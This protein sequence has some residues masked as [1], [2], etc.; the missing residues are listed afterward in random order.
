MSELLKKYESIDQSK[1]KEAFVKVLDRVKKLTNDF[2]TE[3]KKNNEIAEQVLDSV[4]QK[5]PDAIKIVKREPKSKPAPKKT[6]K[7]KH[8]AKATHK[9][10][11]APVAKN[12]DNNIMTVAK[13]IQKAGESWKDAMERAKVVLKERKEKVFEKQ[14]TELEKLYALVKT[15][16]ELIGFSK[17]DIERDAVRDAKPKG[18]RFVTKEG[19]TSNQYGTYDNKL[20]RKYWETRDRHSDRLSPNYPKNMPLLAEGGMTDSTSDRNFII[21][22][23]YIENYPNDELGEEIEA[24]TTF[25]DIWNSLNNGTNVY[26][27]LGVGDSLVRERVFEEL[28]KIYGVDYKYVYDKWLD[29][30]KY[31]DG[32]SIDSER[33][34]NFLKDD[35][36]KLQKAINEDDTEQIEIFF[37]YWLGSS[38]HLKSLET[39]TNDRMYNFLKEDLETLEKAINDGNKEEVERFFSYWGQ[40]LESLKMANGG[41]LPYMTDPNFGDFQNTGSFADGGSVGSGKNGYVAFYKGKQIDVYA[42]TKYEAQKL[43]SQHF[44]AKKDYEVNVVLAELDGK[45]YINSAMFAKGGSFSDNINVYEKGKNYPVK[46]ISIADYEKYGLENFPNFSKSGSISGMKKQYY[47]KDALLVRCGNYIYNVTSKPEIYFNGAYELGGMFMNTDLAGHTGGGTGG[48]D[49]NAPLNGFSGTHYTGLVG[50]TGAMSSGELF[51]AGGAMAQNQQVIN[52]ASQSYVNYYLG[53]GAGQGIYKDGGSIPNNYEGRTAENVWKNWTEAQ[54]SHFLLDHSELLDK[55]RMENNLGY[56]RTIQKDKTFSELTPLTK[57]VLEAHIEKGQYAKGGALKDVDDNL[58]V[59]ISK[60]Q[61]DYWV[62]TSK[63]TTKEQAEEMARLVTSV[64]GETQDVKTVGQV[65]AHSKTIYENGGSIEEG[66]RVTITTNSLGKDYV[67]MSGTIT[68]RKLLNDKYSVK[69]S[70]GLEMAFSKDEFKHDSINPR[71]ADGGAFAPNVSNGTQ[72]MSEVYA[73]GGAIDGMLNKKIQKLA[74]VRGFEIG[75]WATSEY[76]KIMTQA[77]VESLTDAN[78]HDEAKEVVVKAEGKT[79]W[80]DDLYQ[81]ESFNPDEKVSSFAREVARECDYDGYDIIN[82][83]FFITKTA[84]SKV[85]TMIEDLFLK[86]KTTKSTSSSKLSKYIDHD[87]I[88]TVTLKLKGKVVTISGSDVLNGANLMEDGGD[89]S[90]IAN[91]VPKRDVVSVELKNGETV[92]PING[93]W[94][95]KGAELISGASSTSKKDSSK[96]IAPKGYVFVNSGS[97]RA[98]QQINRGDTKYVSLYSFGGANTSAGTTIMF[99]AENDYEKIKG[100]RGVSPAKNYLPA[101]SEWF[102]RQ[103]DKKLDTVFR[104]IEQKESFA[105]GGFMNGVYADGG[106]IEEGSTITLKNDVYASYTNELIPKGTKLRLI[107]TPPKVYGKNAYFVYAK[108]LNNKEEIRTDKSNFVEKIKELESS[109]AD[110]GF[111]NSVE[112]EDGEIMNDVEFADGGFMNDVYANGGAMN[113][114]GEI[115]VK[116]RNFDVI[117]MPKK[118]EIEVQITRADTVDQY[119]LNDAEVEWHQERWGYVIKADDNKKFNKALRVLGITQKYADGGMFDDNDGFMRAD[120]NNNYR[121]PEMEVH[122][123]T[124]DEPIDLTS[125][126]SSKTNNVVIQPLN[127]DIDLSDDNR[128]RARM[129]QSN[130][131]SAKDFAKIN[132]RAF[133][134]IEELPMPTSHTHKND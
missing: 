124:I 14:K 48:L 64:R 91:Y 60:T 53:E 3:D 92:H 41:S 104:E 110:G 4:M 99:M 72:F 132:P 69:L 68:S 98:T 57:R 30:D 42:D 50:E 66:D 46:T 26:D 115:N 74:D 62:I 116:K 78:F 19:T 45:P 23:W 15:K 129:T 10:T 32:G 28:S 87:D 43:A 133:E 134:F 7:A 27:V 118:L 11:S 106:N 34:F 5:N 120:N 101:K 123:D 75:D 13:Q 107:A 76:N 38:G 79:K 89:L 33:L 44:K 119:G 24:D 1:L 6:H 80:S 82:A 73:D 8:T 111:M 56:T 65:K 21:K 54:R 20:G 17:S 103:E 47:G 125:N 39:K 63:P 70:N 37:S 114:S 117:I 22:D 59:S 31:S 40:H 122:V 16:K 86:S 112:L 105:D 96:I 71:F 97:H 130:R 2:T 9:A 88:K 51:E 85:A 55:D 113:S 61:D 90:K 102:S 35:L 36:E 18:A 29:S 94:I 131:G 52:D 121:Y 12:S 109:F 100:I 83:Y 126:V 81:S 84:G 127:E 108:T 95:K 128:V 25:K 58:Y 49:P 77:L 93:Y 67:G